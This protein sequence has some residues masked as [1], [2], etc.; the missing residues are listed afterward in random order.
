MLTSTKGSDG[1]DAASER[2]PVAKWMLGAAIPIVAA[3]F[4]VRGLFAQSIALGN[5]QF[6]GPFILMGY[7]VICYSLAMICLAVFLHMQYFWPESSGRK[8][9]PQ[10]IRILSAIVCAAGFLAVLWQL[11][12]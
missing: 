8:L 12:V 11:F 6:F 7:G 4:G 3:F 10:A 1:L 2:T 9:A 5:G